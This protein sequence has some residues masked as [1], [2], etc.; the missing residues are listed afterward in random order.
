MIS[1]STKTDFLSADSTDSVLSPFAGS[2]GESLQSTEKQGKNFSLTLFSHLAETLEQEA[3]DIGT[4]LVETGKK[5]PRG[6]HLPPADEESTVL[7]GHFLPSGIVQQV[8]ELSLDKNTG[9]TEFLKQK[10]ILNSPEAESFISDKDSAPVAVEKN[11]EHLRSFL[12]RW[13]IF[14]IVLY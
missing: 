13:M 9:D 10:A 14:L 2:P 4:T 7:A 12:S 6:N 8:N 3:D 1:I 5:L 11:P